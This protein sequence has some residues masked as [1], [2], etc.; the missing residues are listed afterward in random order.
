M[1]I[2]EILSL[3]FELK[4]LELLTNSDLEIDEKDHNF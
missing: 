4:A 2:S 3:N 1:N